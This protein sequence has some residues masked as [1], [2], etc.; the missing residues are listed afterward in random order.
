MIWGG[1]VCRTTRE[2]LC[3][4]NATEIAH[5]KGQKTLFSGRSCNMLCRVWASGVVRKINNG[6]TIRAK[7]HARIGTIVHLSMPELEGL[8][9]LISYEY[10][11][12]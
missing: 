5:S 1:N 4:S 12:A 10:T 11:Q 7:L 9:R 2:R 8:D 6:D 3:V